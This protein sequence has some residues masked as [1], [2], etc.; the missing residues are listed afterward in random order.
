MPNCS[1]KI[2]NFDGVNIPYMCPSDLL[3]HEFEKSMRSEA[4]DEK[5]LHIEN[6]MF[7]WLRHRVC[8]GVAERDRVTTCIKDAGSADDEADLRY[9]LN[10]D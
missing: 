1:R 7:L 8:L 6:G 5:W 2:R 4:H 9:L 3:V 10:L